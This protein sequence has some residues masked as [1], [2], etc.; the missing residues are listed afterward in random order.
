MN[1]RFRRG[2][3]LDSIFHVKTRKSTRRFQFLEEETCHQPLG[4]TVFNLAQTVWAGQTWTPLFV[5]MKKDRQ[6]SFTWV[7]N[8]I[9][10]SSIRVL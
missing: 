7:F 6:R 2:G 8:K 9:G 3:R 1:G 4:Q 10:G 5:F